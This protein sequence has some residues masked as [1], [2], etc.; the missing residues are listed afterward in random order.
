MGKTLKNQRLCRR[1]WRMRCG[2]HR[3][4]ASRLYIYRN[5]TERETSLQGCRALQTCSGIPLNPVSGRKPD[6]RF[7]ELRILCHGLC[8]WIGEDALAEHVF[9]LCVVRFGSLRPV[10]VKGMQESNTSIVG[11]SGFGVDVGLHLVTTHETSPHQ[12]GVGL[13]I[14]PDA[15]LRFRILRGVSPQDWAEDSPL[16]PAQV[17]LRFD[18]TRLVAAN[19]MAPIGIS[20]VRCRCREIGLKCE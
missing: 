20:D 17:K 13:G 12:V 4:D 3:N 7:G 1:F 16:N 11:F 18:P 5:L 8:D 19:V 9:V 15:P 14:R 6:C 10:I 2:L